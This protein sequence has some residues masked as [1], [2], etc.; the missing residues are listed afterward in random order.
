LQQGSYFVRAFTTR[1]L[2]AGNNTDA[3]KKELVVLGKGGKMALKETEPASIQ[4]L[5]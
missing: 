5:S 4:L 3:Y 1:M 2:N